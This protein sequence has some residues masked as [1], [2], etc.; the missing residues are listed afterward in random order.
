[1]DDGRIVTPRK[2]LD[3]LRRKDD[4]V[5]EWANERPD[6]FVDAEE[7]IQRRAGEIYQ[8]FPANPGRDEADP[9]VLAEAEARQFT[10]IT[11]EG[12]SFSGVPTRN[13]VRTMPGICRHFGIECRTLP[14]GL[15]MLG[16][17]FQ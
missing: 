2:V 6:C 5:S 9:F 11:Y 4:D 7:P 8:E 17:E 13:W 10:V 1:L 16:G 15:A 3:E 12:R 14:E